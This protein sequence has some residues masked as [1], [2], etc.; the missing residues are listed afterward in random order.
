MNFIEALYNKKYVMSII[1]TW[2][3]RWLD[4]YVNYDTDKIYDDDACDYESFFFDA[5]VESMMANGIDIDEI[6]E[7]EKEGRLYLYDLPNEVHGS[8]IRY[9]YRDLFMDYRSNLLSNVSRYNTITLY[10]VIL[11][12]RQSDIE[13]QINR[14]LNYSGGGLYWTFDKDKAV[15]YKGN[16]FIKRKL[17]VLLSTDIDIRS[18]MINI[19]DTIKKSVNFFIEY[20]IELRECPSNIKLEKYMEVD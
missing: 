15:P 3:N 7:K 20:E 12:H 1:E 14:V 2:Y 11:L 18:P 16:K 4:D 17:R 10:R 8:V 19:Y 9:M 5:I 13:A 6:Y